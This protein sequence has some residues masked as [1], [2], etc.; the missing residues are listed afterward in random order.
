M[1]AGRL[2]RIVTGCGALDEFTAAFREL[3]NAT[4]I[5]LPTATPLAVQKDVRF[6]IALQDD[7]K[8]KP[9]NVI[10]RGTGSISESFETAENRYRRS[11]ML[12]ELGSLDSMGRILLRELNATKNPKPDFSA[13]GD[14]DESFDVSTLVETVSLEELK[15]E[16]K[17][18]AGFAGPDAAA[19]AR[20]VTCTIVLQ[21]AQEE[22]IKRL[23]AMESQEEGEEGE[24]TQVADPEG[25]DGKPAVAKPAVTSADPRTLVKAMP[26]EGVLEL[27]PHAPEDEDEKTMVSA[28][29][30][31]NLG[32]ALDAIADAED[33]EERGAPTRVV[34]MRAAQEPVTSVRK[35]AIARIVP[36]P[37]VVRVPPA[38]ATPVAVNPPAVIARPPSAAPPSATP[39]SATPPSSAP[40]IAAAPPAAASLPVPT[41]SAVPSAKDLAEVGDES[42][43]SFLLQRESAPPR[44]KPITQAL[45]NPE[46][47]VPKGEL[48]SDAITAAI[49][50]TIAPATGASRPLP[51]STPKPIT[52]RSIASLPMVSPGLGGGTSQPPS[53]VMILRSQAAIFGAL[54]LAVG[55][56]AG[57]LLRGCGDSSVD[58]DRQADADDSESDVLATDIEPSVAPTVD[59]SVDAAV[60]PS[61][62]ATPIRSD[63][64][65]I[66][67]DA[68]SAA[69]A[70]P[71]VLDAGSVASLGCELLL[72]ITP[73]D[74][75]VLIEGTA[76]ERTGDA[77]PIACG[78]SVVSIEH[79]K[80]ANHQ[81][82][83]E[84]V[85]GAPFTL[86]HHMK[87][88]MVTLRV[89]SMPRKAWVTID[90]KGIGKTPIRRVVPAHEDVEVRVSRAGFKPVIQTLTP[91]EDVQLDLQLRRFG[92]TRKRGSR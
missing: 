92:K 42:V 82:E 33:E 41:S 25:V 65:P 74:A 86:L 84:L 76:I 85:S 32:A 77:Y 26:Q 62:D 54:C 61:F 90:G 67:V 18:A 51:G 45:P 14:S 60:A 13:N 40:P 52:T 83:V 12:L 70:D 10:L 91:T 50:E 80:Y 39:P 3:C 64:A 69:G 49:A 37:R 43:S 47:P 44:P 19:L 87:R 53:P 46:G 63:A 59:A 23:V 89:T 38:P 6:A 28:G 16:A 31:P 21:N 24:T 2:A 56:G 9:G 88:D 72:D 7:A 29:P 34:S 11:G 68:S 30:R 73:V 35:P 8:G 55:L 57:F 81:L 66:E 48:G 17:K 78:T 58:G 79:E 36:V 4:S 27:E 75:V 71:E 5:F 1:A 20:L 22:A 15:A